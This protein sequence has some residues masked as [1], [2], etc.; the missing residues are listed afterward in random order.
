MTNQVQ[1][2]VVVL[3]ENVFEILSKK[4]FGECHCQGEAAEDV[5]SELSGVELLRE[6]GMESSF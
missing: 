6:A 1:F 3:E 4:V 2:V 5:I